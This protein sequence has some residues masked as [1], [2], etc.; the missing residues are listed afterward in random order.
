MHHSSHPLIVNYACLQG[1]VLLWLLEPALLADS[2]QA[3]FVRASTEHRDRR[4]LDTWELHEKALAL[5]IHQPIRFT[6]DFKGA[7]R[8]MRKV[9]ADA[10]ETVEEVSYSLRGGRKGFPV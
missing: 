5:H 7:V 8:D 10:E 6:I 3:R 4:L 9:W 1:D 2:Q